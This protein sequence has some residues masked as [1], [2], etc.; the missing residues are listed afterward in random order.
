[1]FNL[2]GR[3]FHA[4]DGQGLLQSSPELVGQERIMFDLLT[5]ST[6][7]GFGVG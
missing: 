6:V 3:H 4:A 1:M 5:R 7:L 2:E